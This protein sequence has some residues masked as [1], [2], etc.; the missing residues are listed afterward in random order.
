MRA[1]RRSLP[2]LMMFAILTGAVIPAVAATVSFDA[3]PAGRE[4]KACV[5][6][7][8]LSMFYNLSRAG[9]RPAGWTFVNPLAPADLLPAAATGWVALTNNPAYWRVNLADGQSL[10]DM[11]VIYFRITGP[12]TLDA[13]EQARLLRAVENGALLWIDQVSGI[14]PGIV[15]FEPPRTYPTRVA[16]GTPPA[17]TPFIFEAVAGIDRRVA[18]DWRSELFHTPFELEG[19][20]INRIG[21]GAEGITWPYTDPAGWL[22]R[23]DVDFQP[24]LTL[25]DAGGTNIGVAGMV[26]QYGSGGILV[27]A[28][29]VGQMI[30]GWGGT[31]APNDVQLP[32]FKFAYNAVA[33]LFQMRQRGS[34][35]TGGAPGVV[36]APVE[37]EW[38][39]P[40]PD[41]QD[42]AGNPVDFGPVIGRPLQLNGCVYAL[43]SIGND[44]RARLVCLDAQPER[45]LDGDGNADDG[46]VSDYSLGAQYDVIWEFQFANGVS[47]KTS[48]LTSA[49]VR[50]TPV[51]LCSTSLVSPAGGAGGSVWCF[52]AI[53]GAQPWVFNVFP[54]N[55]AT[56][57]VCDVSTPV[58]HNGRAYF[59]ASEHDSA[60]PDP[61][62]QGV[63]RTYGRAWC[64][65]LETGGHIDPV[66]VDS[67]D[68][69]VYPDADLNRLAAGTVGE[70]QRALPCFNDPGWIAAVG[71]G[72]GGELPTIMTG[73]PVV[74]PSVNLPD[75]TIIDS[76]MICSTPVSH[77]WSQAAGQIVVDRWIDWSDHAPGSTFALVPAT[78]AG[79]GTA[80]FE[81]RLNE[82]YHSVRLNREADGWTSA[83]RFGDLA[84]TIPLAN[85]YNVD[86][87]E[88]CAKFRSLNVGEEGARQFLGRWYVTP[89]ANDDPL[90][91]MKGCQILLQY[92]A[93][94]AVSHSYF[95]RGPVL[96]Q[97][98][99]RGTWADTPVCGA[100][101]RAGTVFVPTGNPLLWNYPA[102]HETPP[103][104]RVSSRINALDAV[105][106]SVRWRVDTRSLTPSLRFAGDDIQS[107]ITSPVTEDDNL[108]VAAVTDWATG[109]PHADRNTPGRTS[110]VALREVADLQIHL[111][112]GLLDGV[113]I[114]RNAPLIVTLLE[115]GGVV[116]ADSYSI[117]FAQRTVR[118]SPEYAHDVPVVGDTT[119][120]SDAIA[121]KAVSVQWQDTNGGNWT[122]LR[123]FPSVGEFTYSPGFIK[124]NLYPADVD[125]LAIYVEDTTAT[126]ADN[127]PVVG[128]APAEPPFTFGGRN[129]LLNGW[130]DLRNAYADLDG[131][132]S[133][134]ANEPFV[135]GMDLVVSY[136]GFS[137]RTIGWTPP[138]WLPAA[139][140]PVNGFVQVPNP[141]LSLPSERHQAPV[142]FGMSLSGPAVA[143]GTI[144]LGTEGYDPFWNGVFEIPPGGTLAT[145]TLL[146]MSWDRSGNNPRGR[147]VEPAVDANGDVPV[148]SAPISVCGDTAIV[149]SRTLTDP[150]VATGNGYVSAMSTQRTLIAAGS[151]LIE[152]VGSEPVRVLTGSR[153]Q[154]G[155]DPW[156]FGH[157]AK[158][159]SLANGNVLAVDAGAN[160]VLELDPQGRRIWW[161]G[162]GQGTPK[163]FLNRPTDA[164]R[165]YTTHQG[166]K[167]AHTVIADA[168]NKRIVEV[169]TKP[170]TATAP[171]TVN[172]LYVVS[173]DAAPVRRVAGQWVICT[174]D[175]AE[176]FMELEYQKAQPIL[177]PE[178]GELWGYLACAA[179]WNTPLIVEPP[180]FTAGGGF[181]RARLNPPAGTRV[182]GAIIGDP[183]YD[184][185][186]Q[187]DGGKLP[188]LYTG[189]NRDW[190]AWTFLYA[191][192]F[193]NIR[194]V[195]YVN[196]GSGPFTTP[197]SNAWMWVVASRYE[198]L[199]NAP[200][201]VYEFPVVT[202]SA[203][204]YYF[205]RDDYFAT[206]YG[207]I[208]LPSGATYQKDFFPTSAQ[209]L[210]N[211]DYIIVNQAVAP[212]HLSVQNTDHLGWGKA[213]SSEVFRAER[214]KVVLGRNMI[215]DPR[216]LWPEPMS[217]V[218]Y[219]ER[220]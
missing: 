100:T 92:T 11:D 111:G 7:G 187:F 104:A 201:G 199:P 171:P 197:E 132:G 39:Y 50:N 131:S 33:W 78:V 79:D 147:M 142:A 195:Q 96:W 89:L 156:P 173:P 117:D 17:P 163:L 35:G 44:G 32:S 202:P 218:G 107:N 186:A 81:Y 55:A 26:S 106:G 110:V 154:S 90:E 191:L 205:T 67:G 10:E 189:R 91:L 133:Q 185:N 128:W 125:T 72:G 157:L 82:E 184:V 34:A 155:A 214:S 181:Y 49:F 118:V 61:S 141:G 88:E 150:G 76:V 45:D 161:A 176:R 196:Y 28:G 140:H 54:Y 85:P 6:D 136:M 23:T 137:E 220:F 36:K 16:A 209:R 206:G 148:V 95:L 18:T 31:L 151:R 42:P 63:D 216:K 200:M 152:C 19:W 56:A 183:P 25:L 143:G 65:D 119:L 159:T 109:G 29:G 207:T 139:Y 210:S 48:S 193:R 83:R 122:E 52:D 37:A 1:S 145:E 101:V 30:E 153:N 194:H 112:A 105:D 5:L 192:Q 215:P 160:Q 87:P 130:V 217:M 47:P 219:A 166:V 70:P 170:A 62:G 53:T 115:N 69:W 68:V 113:G 84:A 43:T 188:V 129:L 177:D 94:G 71:S 4:I 46:P 126:L 99:Y 204:P 3:S 2:V 93:G 80:G 208:D 40:A 59:V 21:G 168:G 8:N 164:W 20:E 74:T 13:G 116:R 174:N 102:D 98:Q 15:E 27:T 124:L 212:D 158:A 178:T 75:G 114:D 14:T 134:Q 22:H 120:A 144:L 86:F 66:L 213:T 38:Q 108:V 167:W 169:V 162:A 138:A 73:A 190:T 146:A 57:A 121:G 180:R 182:L 175:V 179:N 135:T 24:I 198:G 51:I 77:V 123:V 12:T 41:R 172:E 165:Y 9:V 127:V 149:G 203:L 64:I 103:D 58:V 211:G 97:R 60:L